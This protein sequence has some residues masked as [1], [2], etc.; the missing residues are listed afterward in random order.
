MI[1]HILNDQ[2]TDGTWGHEKRIAEVGQKLTLNELYS[3]CGWKFKD[4]ENMNILNRH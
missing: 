1:I 4:K 3:S 2:C